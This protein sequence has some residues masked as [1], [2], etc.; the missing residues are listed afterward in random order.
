[1]RLSYLSTKVKPDGSNRWK[2]WQDTAKLGDEQTLKE[3]FATAVSKQYIKD[4]LD[5]NSEE[6]PW[7]AEITAPGTKTAGLPL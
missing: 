4:F 2:D 1:M 7:D 3:A 5:P 6:D